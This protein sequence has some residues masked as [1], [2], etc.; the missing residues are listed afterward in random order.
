MTS[1]GEVVHIH[2]TPMQVFWLQNLVQEALGDKHF[3]IEAK[4]IA[5]EFHA[6]CGFQSVGWNLAEL[7]SQDQMTPVSTEQAIAWRCQFANHLELT[8]KN[9]VQVKQPL[10]LGGTQNSTQ[11]R[12]QLQQ[13]VKQHGVAADRTQTCAEEL[14]TA[15]GAATIGNILKPPKPWTDLKARANL[16]QPPIRIVSA[17]EL[18]V[19]IQQKAAAGPVGT[20]HGKTKKQPQ[21]WTS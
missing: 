3:Q 9:K 8:N 14:M 7:S 21:M 11:L 12:E 4:A 19:A 17:A 13:L 16:R 10:M 2:T 6:D 1:N 5:Q 15:L 18:K 20:K